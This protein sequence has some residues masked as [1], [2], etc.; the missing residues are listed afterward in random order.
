MITILKNIVKGSSRFEFSVK[1][2]KT[3]LKV[4]GFSVII[5]QI[6]TF[7]DEEVKEIGLE[8]NESIV[9]YKTFCPNA[10]TEF[11]AINFAG[12]KYIKDWQDIK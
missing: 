6:T 8:S 12:K 9:N 4:F 2:E 11:A 5:K 10:K 3:G 1:E 7:A